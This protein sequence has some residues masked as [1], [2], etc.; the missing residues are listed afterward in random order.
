MMETTVVGSFPTKPSKD[1]LMKSYYEGV[2]PYLEA[3]RS[4]AKAQVNAGIDIVS[5]GQTRDNMVNIFA[6]NL[7]GISV[8]GKAVII[9]EIEFIRPITLNDLK[10]LKS[11]IPQNTQVKGIITGPFTMAKSCLNE[12]YK[13]IEECAF[14]FAD[15]LHEE[16]MSIEGEVNMIQIDEPFFSQS[17]PKYA[18]DIIEIVVDDLKL[19]KALHVC[20]DVSK[21]FPYL[22]EFPIDI[23]NHEFKANPILLEVIADYSFPQKIGYGSVRSDNERVE[24]V[25]EISEHIRRAMNVLGKNKMLIEP[26]CGLRY[27]TE[28]SA[29]QKLI[30][31]VKARD[32][33]LADE[34]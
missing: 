31:M 12:H 3:I 14:A 29:Y 33:I 1:I 22:V 27:L 16:A 32:V 5:D 24:L 9:D 11:L 20:G 25:K 28:E 4:C 8:R 15:A 19:P 34:A 13:S 18:Q 21:I 2:D 10:Y 6:K 26:D 23:L 17:Y 7:G 30:N